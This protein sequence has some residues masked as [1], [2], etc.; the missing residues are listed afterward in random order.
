MEW[1]LL[2]HKDSSLIIENFWQQNDMCLIFINVFH[3]V[4]WLQFSSQQLW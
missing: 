2:Y 4:A 1:F 3:L